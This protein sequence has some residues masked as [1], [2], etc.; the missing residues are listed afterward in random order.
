MTRD[1]APYAELFEPSFEANPYPAYAAW[2][3]EGPVHRTALPDGTPLWLVT[4]YGE[5]REVL[6]DHRRFVKVPRGADGEEPDGWMHGVPEEMR[7][8]MR[9]LLAVD[10]P[11]H[12]RLR[13]LVQKAFT[14]RFV[15]ERRDRVQAIADG[16]LDEVEGRAGRTGRR[17]MDLIDDYAFP[18]PMTVISE[19]LG[20]PHADRGDFR[21]WSNAAIGSDF[22][23]E[24][25]QGIARSMGEFADFLRSL[26][27][28]KRR[29]PGA[30]LITGLL[31]AEEDGETLSEDELLSMIF[32]LIIAGHE[33]TV[34]LI[35][36][37]TLALLSHPD[38]LDK[39]K[40]DPSLVVSAVEELLRYDG[41]AERTTMRFA[42]RDAKVGGVAIPEGEPVMV[43]L[44]S[45]DRDEG[46]FG[47]DAQELDV[48]RFSG[49]HGEHLAFGKG[50]HVCLGA[51]LARME[52]QVAIG[53]L[54]RRLPNLELAAQPEDLSWRRSLLIRGLVSLP[55]AF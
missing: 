28:A 29:E 35:A 5:A 31:R 45:A 54:L 46:R 23:V 27:E 39:L 32:V 6:K 55:L 7:P 11:D 40:A 30:D 41:P 43:A 16:L 22:T 4:R 37:G 26:F 44:A 50:I 18:L 8:F 10:P 15:E 49:G 13:K 20:V 17:E 51:P 47:E 12:T 36:N 1:G 48:S 19:M 33:T 3:R 21:R 2:R 14:P 38:Q 34:N 9:H 24:Y 52:G 25:E 53:T 42:A